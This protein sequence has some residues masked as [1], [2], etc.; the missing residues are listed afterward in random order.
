MTKAQ[1][2]AYQKQLLALSS[3]VRGN[4]NDVTEQAQ[5]PT[6]GEAGGGL[7]NAPMHLGDVGT[8]TY[9][10]ELSST[11]MQTEQD[12]SNEISAALRRI[13]D[14]TFGICEECGQPI[15]EARLQALPY[16]PYC[17]KCADTAGSSPRANLNTGRPRRPE[18]TLA[19]R[20]SQGTERDDSIIAAE[21]ERPLPDS[22][23]GMAGGGTAVGGLAGTNSGDGD[24]AD[25]DLEK[26]TTSGRFKPEAE[27]TNSGYA[28]SA[29]GAVG[30]TPAGKRVAG[31]KAADVE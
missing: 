14:G 1:L 24:P 28:G 29:G 9:M 25:V 31:G 3:D 13:D 16:T 7:S 30:G 2:Q 10:Q 4:L 8:E 11:L 18:D 27:A 26:A 20:A 19:N 6:G 17:V 5:R 23:A 22:A 21:G 15:P 12:M